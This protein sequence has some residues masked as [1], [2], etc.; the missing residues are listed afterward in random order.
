M[1]FSNNRVIKKDKNTYERCVETSTIIYFI[2]YSSNVKNDSLI[3]FDRT[4]KPIDINKEEI[5]PMF[6][7]CIKSGAYNWLS[8]K[9]KKHL[10]K[11]KLSN[12]KE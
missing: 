1:K 5:Y 6:V 11:M 7:K 12:E 2:D 4:M 8:E 3:V 10:T 9:I